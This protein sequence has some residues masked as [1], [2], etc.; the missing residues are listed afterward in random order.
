ME[1]QCDS[2]VHSGQWLTFRKLSFLPLAEPVLNGAARGQVKSGSCPVDSVASASPS[3]TCRPE[4]P[5]ASLPSSPRFGTRAWAPLSPRWPL[6]ATHYPS[7]A[8]SSIL[9]KS[10][11]ALVTG[12]PLL[13]LTQFSLHSPCW[14]PSVFWVTGPGTTAH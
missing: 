9:V 14:L 1:A 4:L 5:G 12:S 3:P 13:S 2:L 8:G 10:S 6:L 7:K 11:G